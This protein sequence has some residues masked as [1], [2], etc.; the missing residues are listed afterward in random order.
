MTNP[1]ASAAGMA[2]QQRLQYRKPPASSAGM[3][4]QLMIIKKSFTTIRYR[5][6]GP[7]AVRLDALPVLPPCPCAGVF[8]VPWCVRRLNMLSL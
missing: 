8:L 5:S 6:E 3:L 1:L 7:A 4:A 2:V